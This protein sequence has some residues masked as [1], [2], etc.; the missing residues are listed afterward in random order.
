VGE[1][2]L[3]ERS[4]ENGKNLAS[5]QVGY[6]QAN[7]GAVQQWCA[8]QHLGTHKLSVLLTDWLLQQTAIPLLSVNNSKKRL[9]WARDNQP[10]TIEEWENISWSDESRILLLY[11][12]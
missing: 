5:K 10:C 2:K 12:D 7:N 9:Q 1:K 3:Y 4:K 11:A 6:K 8:E